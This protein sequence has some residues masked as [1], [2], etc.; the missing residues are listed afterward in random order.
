[1]TDPLPDRWHTRDLPFLTAV[2]A[3]LEANP[4]T[5]I[6]AASV[7]RDLS[8]NPDEVLRIFKNLQR[9]GYIEPIAGAPTRGGD[10][11]VDRPLEVT[12]KALQAVGT[13]PT[14]ETALNR[15][16]AALEAIAENTDDD[17]TRTRARKILDGLAGT[18]RQLGIAVAGAAITGQIPGA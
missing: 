7:G 16:I 4:S 9:G 15:I 13:W 10:T 6:D 8:I 17:D 2:C 14:E 3:Q 5:P 1:M 11:E 12:E 18:G